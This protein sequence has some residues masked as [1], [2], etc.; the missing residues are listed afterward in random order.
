MLQQIAI[1]VGILIALIA[2]IEREEVFMCSV[3]ALLP[4]LKGYAFWAVESD[5]DVPR[6]LQSLANQKLK[7]AQTLKFLDF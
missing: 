3:R 1:W 4:N 6:R 7:S 2:S 5:I